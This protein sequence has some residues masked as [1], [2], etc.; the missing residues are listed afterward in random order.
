MGNAAIFAPRRERP[1]LTQPLTDRQRGILGYLWRFS[2]DNDN[3]P[4]YQLIRQAFCFHSD[5][6]GIEHLIALERKGYLERCPALPNKYRFTTK[7][8]AELAAPSSASTPVPLGT[9]A[10]PTPAAHR[11]N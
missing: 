1:H 8:R 4:T 7:A 2:R 9:E 11:A 5:N 10:G 6:A 3:F